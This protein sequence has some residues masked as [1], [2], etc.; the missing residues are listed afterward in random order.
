MTRRR[1]GPEERGV[2]TELRNLN[3]IKVA[4]RGALASMA[5][6]MAQ[7]LDRGL[8]DPRDA[9]AARAQIRQCVVQLREW[10]PAP[11]AGDATAG[12]RSDV[13]AVRSLRVVGEDG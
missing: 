4:D 2:R 13:E 9:I 6:A 8:L 3:Q 1:I 12:A 7:Q 10:A 5:L 11:D